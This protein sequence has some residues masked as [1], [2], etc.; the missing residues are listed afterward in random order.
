MVVAIILARGG[1][2]RIKRKNLKNIKGKPIIAWVIEM[3]KKS[4]LFDKIIV[5][6]DD[7]EIAS[8]SKLLGAETPFKRPKELSD[9][10]AN[11]NDVMSYAVSW[12]RHKNWDLESVCCFYGTSVFFNKTDLIKGQSALSN[13]KISYAFSVTDFDY[14]IFRSFISQKDVGI[15]MLFPEH[16][17]TR[18][19]DLPIAMHDAAQFYWGRPSSWINKEK[20]FNH[21]SVGVMIPRQNVQDIDTEDDWSRAESIF[22]PFEL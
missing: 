12:M 11:T 13:P 17:E 14:P 3:V 20:I 8:L 21:K 6:T 15:K 1:S 18:S 22:Q 9:D 5:S 2:K 4:A 16:Y 19:Q 7:D 10:F